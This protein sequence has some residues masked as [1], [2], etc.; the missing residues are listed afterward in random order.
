MKTI[1]ST[2]YFPPIEYFLLVNKYDEIIIEKHEN[3]VKQSYRN[4]CKVLSANGVQTLS[5]P[6]K[7]ASRQKTKIIDVEIDYKENWQKQHLK[8]LESA[9]KKSP[10]FEYYIPEFQEFFSKKYKFLFD[11]NAKILE[12]LLQ[13]LNIEKKL[14][15]S[16]EYEIYPNISDFRNIIHPKKQF[17]T[18]FEAKKYTQV[19]FN[20]FEFQENLSILDLLFNEGT[21]SYNFL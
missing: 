16:E 20:K 9:Y 2:A 10:F 13:I 12:K 21:N 8:T 7:K 1:F 5:I 4:R 6:V 11:F 19:F 3:Y 17:Q 15:F 14:N 18:N